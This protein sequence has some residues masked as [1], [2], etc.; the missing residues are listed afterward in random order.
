MSIFRL[1][2]VH[3][4]FST[5]FVTIAMLERRLNIVY[6]L[7]QQ[8]ALVEALNAH[9]VATSPQTSGF[10]ARLFAILFPAS[11]AVNT[12]L[13]VLSFCFTQVFAYQL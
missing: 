1:V 10:T 6:L 4:L 7:V 12:L 8:C 13:L 9:K 5:F 2:P 3:F 11:P